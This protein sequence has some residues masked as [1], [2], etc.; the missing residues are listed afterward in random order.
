M[1]DTLQ[2]LQA[3]GPGALPASVT[4]LING[5][6][7]SQGNA[8]ATALVQQAGQSL[9]A[10]ALSHFKSQGIPEHPRHMYKPLVTKA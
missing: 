5:A 8:L 10:A 6:A 9:L 1:I 4:A 7:G 2:R 3:S